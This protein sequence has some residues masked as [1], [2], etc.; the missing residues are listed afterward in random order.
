MLQVVATL[1]AMSISEPG[2]ERKHLG[3]VGDQAF[4][5]IDHLSC[6]FPHC[7]QPQKYHLADSLT[8][9]LLGVGQFFRKHSE[10]GTPCVDMNLRGARQILRG[11][12]AGALAQACRQS[13]A[14]TLSTDLGL[15]AG[16]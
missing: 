10:E 7:Q 14:P 4:T 2:R 13:R 15:P 16:C 11:K 6:L 8:S 9:T 12:R 1:T 5:L 3:V